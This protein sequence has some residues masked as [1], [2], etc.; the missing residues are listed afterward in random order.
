[1]DVSLYVAGPDG[2]SR[3]C[4]APAEERSVSDGDGAP[5][6]VALCDEHFD[7]VSD[8]ANAHYWFIDRAGKGARVLMR[9]GGDLPSSPWGATR[10]VSRG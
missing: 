9:L 1:M 10:P 2:E 7:Y 4:D 6:Q 3:P 5:V 8:R